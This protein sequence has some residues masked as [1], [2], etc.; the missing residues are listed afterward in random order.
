MAYGSALAVL[1]D[2]TRAPEAFSRSYRANRDEDLILNEVLPP[3]TIGYVEVIREIA[4]TQTD[5]AVKVWKRLV[6][7][8]PHLFPRDVYPLVNALLQKH[9]YGEARRV[10]DE[11]INFT[12][13]HAAPNDNGPALWDGGFES[14]LNGYDFAWHFDAMSDGVQTSFDSREKHSGAR[15]LRLDFGGKRNVRLDSPCTIAVV[16]PRETYVL[17]GWIKTDKLTSEEG[18]RLRIGADGSELSK[19]QA[20]LGSTPWSEVQTKWT[21]GSATRIAASA[22]S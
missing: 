6:T 11:G 12:D 21:A 16:E 9:N 18:V 19:T 4:E 13:S 22:F 17:S 15:S 7:L 20:V 2:P 14:G 5:I 10:W 1:A 3:S 8:H